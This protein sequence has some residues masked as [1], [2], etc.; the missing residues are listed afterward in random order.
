MTNG[1]GGAGGTRGKAI[2]CKG[3]VACGFSLFHFRSF[4]ST[5]ARLGRHA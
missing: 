4:A 3:V 5:A 2:K 1:N